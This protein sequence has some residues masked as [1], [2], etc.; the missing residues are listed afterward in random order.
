MARMLRGLL[1]FALTSALAAQWATDPLRNLAIGDRSGEQVLAKIAAIPDGGCYIAWF[2]NSAGGYAVY[3][4]RLDAA[5]VE[6]WPHGGVLLSN[7]PQSSSLVDWDLICLDDGTAV[8]AFTDVRSGPDLDV[9]AYRVAQNGTLLWGNNGVALSNNS[10]DEA[11]PRLCQT[12]DGAIVCVWPNTTTRTLRAQRLDLAGNQLHA[13]DGLRIPG[14][15]NDTPAFA[16]VVAGDAGSF[17]VSWVRAMAFNGTRHLHTQK[18]DPAGAPVW[19]TQRQVVFDLAVLPIAHEPR[20]LPDGAGGAIYAWH[21]AVG[22]TFSVRVQRLTAAGVEVFPHNGVDA[23]THAMGKFDPALVWHQAS[24]SILVFWNERNSAQSSW[25]ISGN[26]IDAT[27]ARLW[28]PSGAVLLPVNTVNKLPPVAVGYDDGAQVF[29][30]ENSLGPVQHKL[31]GMRVRGDGSL[32]T[33]VVDVSRAVSEKLRL[34]A[35][36]S[37]SGVAMVCWT[38]KRADA[39]DTYAQ[40]FNPDGSLG[41]RLASVQLYGC[42]NPAGSFAVSDLPRLGGAF[43]LVVDNPLGTQAVGSASVFVLAS[44]PA[45]GF[46]CGVSVP[47]LGMA[48]GGAAG[49]L[50]FDPAQPAP[51]FVGTPWQGGSTPGRLPLLMPNNLSLVGRELFVQGAIVDLTVGALAP[52]ALT[53]A[54]RLRFGY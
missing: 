36:V 32:A 17:I 51:M 48:G 26:R 46:P 43:S 38:D 45:A 12:S 41:A 47:G 5:G 42:A 50:L 28:G 16:R 29:V 33:P 18:F 20:L 24:Q 30:F 54:A 21:Y 25:G 13:A 22:L 6:Q 23:A 40:N 1:P 52:V 53:R 27:G 2:D 34:Q 15:A 39:G 31:L 9:Y 14:D 49:E 35:A 37:P 7:Q 4:Q 44:A 10:D 19:G 11:N 3:M 8:V